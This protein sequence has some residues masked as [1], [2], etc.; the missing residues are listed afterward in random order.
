MRFLAVGINA[1]IRKTLVFGSLAKGEVNRAA[2][3]WFDAAGIADPARVLAQAGARVTCVTPVAAVI[4]EN[5]RAHC[6]DEAISLVMVPGTGS[7]DHI[8]LVV[9]RTTGG[10]SEFALPATPM[11]QN[12]AEAVRTAG[13]T[14]GENVDLVI[15]YDRSLWKETDTDFVAAA[16]ADLIE[17]VVRMNKPVL[18][19]VTAPVLKRILSRVLAYFGSSARHASNLILV[20][21]SRDHLEPLIVSRS[22][23]V[24]DALVELAKKGVSAVMTDHSRETLFAGKENGYSCGATLPVAR[25]PVSSAGS[26][27]AFTAGLALGLARGDSLADAVEQGHTLAAMNAAQSRAASIRPD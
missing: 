2:E 22:G 3:Y 16:Y 9:D 25:E 5:Y 15:L 6:R 21:S 11:D 10:A 27:A 18:I 26:G 20:R 13:D 4:E 12:Q 7:S 8:T 1:V 19:D 24:K 14:M 23:D 17:S